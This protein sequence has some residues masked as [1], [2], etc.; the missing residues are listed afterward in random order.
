MKK[1]EH[2]ERLLKKYQEINRNK[3]NYKFKVEKVSFSSNIEVFI[4]I[5]PSYYCKMPIYL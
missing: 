5:A 3:E 2:R 1:E 4:K